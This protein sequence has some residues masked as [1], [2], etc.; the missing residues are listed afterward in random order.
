MASDTYFDTVRRN[1][2]AALA[3]RHSLPSIHTSRAQAEAGGLISYG[4][5][6]PGIYRQ[7][8]N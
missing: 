8:G 1:Q 2:V 3:A 4:A 5:S 6:I 7:A